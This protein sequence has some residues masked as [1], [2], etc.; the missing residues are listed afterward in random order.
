MALEKISTGTRPTESSGM[1]GRMVL[2][3][4]C[5]FFFGGGGGWKRAGLV[6]AGRYWEWL[7]QQVGWL[8]LL[9]IG[10]GLLIA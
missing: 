7:V 6:G 4:W 1:D 2:V 3:W 5:F 10:V 8:K 9:G